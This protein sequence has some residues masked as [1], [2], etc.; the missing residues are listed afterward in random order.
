[1]SCGAG[2]GEHLNEWYGSQ[3]PEVRLRFADGSIANFTYCTVG[4][5]TSGGERV[6]VFAPGLGMASEDF[7]KFTLQADRR[8]AKS[9]WFAEKGYAAQLRLFFESIREG[10]TPEVTVRGGARATIACLQ[11]LEAARTLAPC[12]INWE[13]ALA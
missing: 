6:E 8:S 11:M 7:K 1:M 13:A 10:K 12:E 9:A 5:A 3:R 2:K 4:S